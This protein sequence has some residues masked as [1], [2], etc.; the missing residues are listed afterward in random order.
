[1]SANQPSSAPKPYRGVGLPPPDSRAGLA[2]LGAFF[3][4]LVYVVVFAGAY[5]AFTAEATWIVGLNLVLSV[6]VTFF[7]VSMIGSDR[8]RASDFEL[9]FART[10]QA[11]LAAG[12]TLVEASPLGGILHEYARVAHDQRNAVR[13]HALA[14]GP[15]IY[16]A[17]FAVIA[18]FLVG[19]A[20]AIGVDPNTLGLAML[21]ELPAFS[22]LVLTTGI[23]VLSVGRTSEVPEFSTFVLRRWARVADPSFP[24]THSLSEVPWAA[25]APLPV[26]PPLWQETGAVTP[27]PS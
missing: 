9:E 18:A 26:N 22:L 1:M 10:V 17:A 4:G 27:A 25:Q 5:S 11:H 16:S 6:L 19:L 7:L 24:F 20:Y 2:L 13:E 15:A 21:F 14:A 8:A 23:L 12:E 3:L